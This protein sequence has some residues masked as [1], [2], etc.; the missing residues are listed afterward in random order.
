MKD[1]EEILRYF[2]NSIYTLLK[3]TLMQDI[4]LQNDLQEIRIR[5]GRF[6]LLKTRQ[7]DIIIDYKITTSEI[8][9]ILEKLCENSIYAYKNQI[10]EGFLTVRGGHRIGITGTAVTEEN[11]IV[12]LKYI[13]SLNFRIAREVI[14]CSNQILED[15]I[16]F[17]THSIYNTLIVS[18]P[19]KGKTTMLRDIIRNISNGIDKIHFKGLTCGVVDERGEIA[20]MYKGVPQ[21]DVGIRTDIIENISKSKGMRMLIRSMAPEVICCDEIG[22]KEDIQAIRRSNNSWSKRNFYKSWKKHGRYKKQYTNQ[23]FN[24]NKTNRKSTFFIKKVLN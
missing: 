21:N 16:D 6:I 20:A 24:R 1:I 12:N 22:S 9:Q 10:C 23:L 2:P 14:G 19:G 15:I 3:N 11:K 18:P 5:V 8:L 13:T 17:E 7:A 4:N